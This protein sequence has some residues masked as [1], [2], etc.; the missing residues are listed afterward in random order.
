M[1]TTILNAPLQAARPVAVPHGGFFRTFIAVLAALG[2]GLA[3]AARYEQLRARGVDHA[4]AVQ[5]AL[6]EER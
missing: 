3:A 4:K 2:D 6:G 5:T 1:S